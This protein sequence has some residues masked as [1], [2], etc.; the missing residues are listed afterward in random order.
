[1]YQAFCKS[2]ISIISASLSLEAPE[3]VLFMI[4]FYRRDRST[5]VCHRQPWSEEQFKQVF[6]T[7]EPRLFLQDR[8]GCFPNKIKIL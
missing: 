5:Q 6:L 7:L 1:M 3:S 4:P 2:F 8:L